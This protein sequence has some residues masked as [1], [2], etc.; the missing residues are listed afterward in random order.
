MKFIISISIAILFFASA[1]AQE[2]QSLYG[3]I[4]FGRPMTVKTCGKGALGRSD[5]GESCVKKSMNDYWYFFPVKEMPE[6]LASDGSNVLIKTIDGDVGSVT[7]YTGG[8]SKQGLAYL[9]LSIKYGKPTREKT[10]QQS[11]VNGK[12]NEI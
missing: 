9:A 5:T 6:Y 8:L 1:F 7:L 3:D 2:G 11:T 10:S 12:R 4:N